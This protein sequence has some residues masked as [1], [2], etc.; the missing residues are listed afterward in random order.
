MEGPKNGGPV[1]LC[2]ISWERKSPSRQ[3]RNGFTRLRISAFG[4]DGPLID[5]DTRVLGP[6]R[7]VCR[8]VVFRNASGDGK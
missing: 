3:E 2:L 1:H 6:R 4:W 7:M 8:N 5:R